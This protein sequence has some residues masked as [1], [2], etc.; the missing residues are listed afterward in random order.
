[1]HFMGSFIGSTLH[2]VMSVVVICVII[3]LLRVN[4]FYF[5]QLDSTCCTPVIVVTFYHGTI[6]MTTTEVDC[7]FTV[8]HIR[9]LVVSATAF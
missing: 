6:P 2:I 9:R 7:T 4:W 5:L 3:S 8:R 1:M